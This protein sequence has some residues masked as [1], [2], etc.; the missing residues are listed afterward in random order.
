MRVQ[1][2]AIIGAGG[3]AS[4]IR[5]VLEAQNRIEPSFELLGFLVEREHAEPGTLVDGLPILGDLDAL[6]GRAPEVRVICGIGACETRRRLVRAAEERGFRFF[7]ALHPSASI[8]PRVTLGTGI[9]VAA[10]TVVTSRIRIG[11]HVHLNTGC[12]VAHDDVL[13]DFVTCAPGVNL[14][15]NVHVGEG[16]YLGI[17]STVIQKRRIGPWATVAAGAVVIE[18]VPANATVAGVPARVKSTRVTGWQLS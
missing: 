12:T 2:V 15:G 7:N 3:H 4:E 1:R 16:A 11:N 5:D 6:V 17:G 9:L 18:D 10:G 8:T 14:A 13:E